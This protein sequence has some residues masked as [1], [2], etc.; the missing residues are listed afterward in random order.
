[1]VVSGASGWME[2]YHDR[3]PVILEPGHFYAWLDGSIGTDAPTPASEE[4]LRECLVS[5]PMN[6]TGVGDDN[7]T[8]L[9]PM[10]RCL[11]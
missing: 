5:P 9:M 4:A 11:L 7:P 3:M 8:I 10:S 6:R 2:V 1:M